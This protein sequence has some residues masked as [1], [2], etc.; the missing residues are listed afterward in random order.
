MP[1]FFISVSSGSSIAV[2]RPSVMA[3]MFQFMRGIA[4]VAAIILNCGVAFGEVD[5]SSANYVM[6]GCHAWVNKD[7][8]SNTL[9]EQGICFGMIKGL[10]YNTG[11]CPPISATHG[12]AVRVVM[13]YIDERPE[14]MHENFILLAREALQAAWPC[15]R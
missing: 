2:M 13:Q 10:S 3:S 1:N 7:T 5:Q 9:L 15:K 4:L 14:R 11:V 12:Q 8:S 6:R